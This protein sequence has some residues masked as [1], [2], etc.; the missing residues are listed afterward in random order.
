M[1]MGCIEKKMKTNNSRFIY[2]LLNHE[3]ILDYIL[4]TNLD[5]QSDRLSNGYYDIVTATGMKLFLM[6]DIWVTVSSVGNFFLVMIKFLK[7][8]LELG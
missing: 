3:I 8:F 2:Y 5:W 7:C 6:K 4:Q 1:E